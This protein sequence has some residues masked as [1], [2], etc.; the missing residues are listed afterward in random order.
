MKATLKPGLFL[1]NAMNSVQTSFVLKLPGL[2]TDLWNFFRNVAGWRGC[3]ASCYWLAVG[4]GHV[5]LILGVWEGVWFILK[6]SMIASVNYK[7]TCI[8]V[9]F[10]H[11]NNYIININ[12]LVLKSNDEAMHTGI[13]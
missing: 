10:C 7:K 4:Q 3:S 13:W 8:T 5:H 11:Y 2:D 1:H 9:F 6:H 12:V